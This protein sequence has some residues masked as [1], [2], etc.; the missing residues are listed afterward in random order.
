MAK[1]HGKNLEKAVEN[2]YLIS[3]DRDAGARIQDMKG[4]RCH[5]IPRAMGSQGKV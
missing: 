4:F 5:N 2:R 1:R 3:P